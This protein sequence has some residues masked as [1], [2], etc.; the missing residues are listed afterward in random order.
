MKSR[1]PHP[2]SRSPNSPASAYRWLPAR[3]EANASAIS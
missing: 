2:F 3:R 1:L